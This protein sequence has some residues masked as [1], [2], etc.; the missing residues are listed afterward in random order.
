MP[1]LLP[2]TIVAR[3]EMHAEGKHVGLGLFLSDSVKKGQEIDSYT[4]DVKTEQK[5]QQDLTRRGPEDMR[6]D[7]AL[8]RLPDGYRDGPLFI[9]AYDRRN[10]TRF[11]NHSC[12]PNCVFEKWQREGFPIIKVMALQDMRAGTELTVSYNWSPD[13]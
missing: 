6:Y 13:I 4:G 3:S 10:K 5:L 12:E 11:I 7:I 9:D 1:R 8:E 2:S